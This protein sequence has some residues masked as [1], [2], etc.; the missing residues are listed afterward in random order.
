MSFVNIAD[1][2]MAISVKLISKGVVVSAGALAF[3]F[4]TPY[5]RQKL[6]AS[7]KFGLKFQAF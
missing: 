2:R 1:Q 5:A 6:S 4:L 3:Q 7:L